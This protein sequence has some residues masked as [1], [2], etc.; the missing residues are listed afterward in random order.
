MAAISVTF[1]ATQTVAQ[2][3]SYPDEAGFITGSAGHPGIVAFDATTMEDGD[4]EVNR[5]VLTGSRLFYSILEGKVAGAYLQ[6]GEEK[7]DL[8]KADFVGACFAIHCLST[9]A[10]SCYNLPQGG[11]SCYCGRFQLAQ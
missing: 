3:A 2:S 9:Q 1:I 4:Y 11:C 5:D 6:N 10:I 8:K 7:F